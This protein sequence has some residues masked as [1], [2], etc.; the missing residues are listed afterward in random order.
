MFA[1]FDREGATDD[2][3]PDTRS[4]LVVSKPPALLFDATCRK[5]GWIF[6]LK[7]VLDCAINIGTRPTAS[8]QEVDD[9]AGDEARVSI[10]QAS[11][12]SS[13]ATNY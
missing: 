2:R 13:A 12:W 9:H 3:P 6:A 1:R 8:A 4:H 11:K 5:A 7:W 10:G